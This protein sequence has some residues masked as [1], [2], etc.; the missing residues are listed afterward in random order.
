M[1][2]VVVQVSGF[3]PPHAL[4]REGRVLRQTVLRVTMRDQAAQ[5]GFLK[6]LQDLGLELVDLRQLPPSQTPAGTQAGSL[7]DHGDALTIEVVIRGSIGDLA[8]SALC[9]HVEV[10]HLA[11]RLLVSDRRL[12]GQVLE[13][14][15]SADAAVEYAVDAPPLTDPYGTPAAPLRSAPS[16]S[17]VVNEATADER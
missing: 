5:Y 2:S 16:S 15:R 17:R 4:D 11:T 13:W 7:S 9:D 10:T 8:V 1:S 3:L 6:V 14:A 12:L